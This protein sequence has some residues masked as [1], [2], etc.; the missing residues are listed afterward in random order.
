MTDDHL[1]DKELD[2][3]LASSAHEHQPT[4]G[5]TA[6][7]QA[8][9]SDRNA[10]GNPDRT[11]CGW[12]RLHPLL[13]AASAMLPLALGF[14]MGLYSLP[15][16]HSFEDAASDWSAVSMLALEDLNLPVEIDSE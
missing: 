13:G 12:L 7:I 10:D 5:L 9:S 3:L 1:T 15:A 16:Q 14:V 2:A 6:R 4:P 8:S 11:W